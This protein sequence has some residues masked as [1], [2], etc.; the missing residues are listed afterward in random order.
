MELVRKWEHEEVDADNYQSVSAEV[1]KEAESG[2]AAIAKI[3]MVSRLLAGKDSSSPATRW[4]RAA[5]KASAGG[6]A[7]KLREAARLKALQRTPYPMVLARIKLLLDRL[8][9]YKQPM[10]S[11][12]MGSHYSSNGARSMSPTKMRMQ[13]S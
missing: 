4:M 1:H 13:V 3:G 11:G 9:V 12:S 2:F 8:H 7:R 6:A 10:L 5:V